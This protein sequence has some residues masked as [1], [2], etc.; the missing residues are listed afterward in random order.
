MAAA[1]LLADVAPVPVLVIGGVGILII[2]GVCLALAAAMF[3][4]IRRRRRPRQP[5]AGDEETPQFPNLGE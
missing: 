5:S 1:L 3:G 2:S 4:W